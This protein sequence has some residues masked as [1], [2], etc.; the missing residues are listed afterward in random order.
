MNPVRV[1]YPDCGRQK[2][3]TSTYSPTPGV[4]TIIL[5]IYGIIIKGKY[6]NFKLVKCFYNVEK[7]LI[8]MQY[9]LYTYILTFVTGG[10]S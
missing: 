2:S 3:P 10:R 4:I 9:I 6:P 8:D 7:K 5:M 1:V